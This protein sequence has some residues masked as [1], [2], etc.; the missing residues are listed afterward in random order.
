VKLLLDEMY[1]TAIAEQLRARGYD[2]LSVH[3]AAYRRLE[4]EPDARVF[5]AAL[6]D[7]RVI[8]TEDISGFHRLRRTALA[9]GRQVPGLIFTTN[10]RFPRSDPGTLGRLVRA[11][12]ALLDAD[13]SLSSNLFLQDPPLS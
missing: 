4:G 7:E 8:V 1:L 2:V 13:P 11:L 6:A 9:E 3:D 10:H 12:A 5:A